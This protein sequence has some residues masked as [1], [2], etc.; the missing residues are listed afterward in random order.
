[1]SNDLTIIFKYF[2]FFCLGFDIA[3]SRKYYTVLYN[4]V[5]TPGE[6]RENFSAIIIFFKSFLKS[7]LKRLTSQYKYDIIYS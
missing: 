1:M 4:P 5:A 3:L 7:F 6:C 2:L